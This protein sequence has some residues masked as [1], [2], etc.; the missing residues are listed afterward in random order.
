MPGHFPDYPLV[1]AVVIMDRV[2]V[3][4]EEQFNTILNTFSFPQIKFL[5]PIFPNNEFNIQFKEIKS[6]RVDFTVGNDTLIYTKGR[7]SYQV[8]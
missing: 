7:L 5:I 6:G 4:F 8:K 1:P 2:V 3:A